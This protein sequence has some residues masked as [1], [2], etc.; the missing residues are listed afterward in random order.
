[1]EKKN[2]I[3]ILI[4]IIGLIMLLWGKELGKKEIK[5]DLG[6]YDFT[7]GVVEAYFRRGTIGYNVGRSSITYS[8]TVG[9]IRYMNN[10][11]ML[12]YKL[13][14]SPDV[15]DKFVVAYN[16]NDPQKSILLGDYAIK[17]D[18][19]FNNFIKEGIKISF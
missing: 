19:D 12:F 14:S 2:Y 18:E 13:P 8:Y 17:N 7:I 10:Y 15:N 3:L 11:D 5:K 16:K 6:D 1:M 9:G 4:I